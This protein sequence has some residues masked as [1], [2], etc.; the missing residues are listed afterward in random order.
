MGFSLFSLIC[1]LHSAIATTTG[2][3]MMFYMADIYS[4]THGAEVATKLIGSTSR[5]QLLIRTSDS[6]SGLLLFAIG[7]LVFMV[8]FVKDK[9]FHSF[10]A[11]GCFL[12]HTSMAV[13][14]F[15]FERRVE[16]LAWDWLRLLVGDI[17]LALS[18][19]FFLV[20]SWKDK[21]D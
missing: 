14:R 13:W 12:L 9:E 18:W 3:L 15:N 17:V 21:Y 1:F 5:D 8:A 20:H 4:F 11:K 19:I 7:F 16:D 6:F 2:V 10:F